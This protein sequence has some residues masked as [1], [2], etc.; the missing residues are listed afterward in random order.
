MKQKKTKLFLTFLFMLFCMQT[1]SA[2]DYER[3]VAIYHSKRYEKAKEMFLKIIKTQ[4][5]GNSLYYLGEI[6]KIEGKYKEAK[7]YFTRAVKAKSIGVSNLKS[8][9]WNIAAIEEQWGEYENLV[10]ICHEIW[11]KMKD[12][13]A[14]RKIDAIINKLQWSNNANAV[15][16]YHKGIEMKKL[17]K[18]DEAVLNFREALKYD[19]LFIAPKFELGILAVQDDDMDAAEANLNPVISKI[20]FYAEAN[21]A[22]GDVYFNKRNFSLARICYERAVRFG[23]LNSQTSYHINIQSAQCYYNEGSFVKAEEL[24]SQ[25]ASIAPEQTEPLTLISAIYIKQKDFE[26]ALNILQKAQS[27]QPD[28]N[29]VLYQLGS[30]YYNRKDERYLANFDKLFNLTKEKPKQPY[31]LIVPIIIRAHYAQ[32]NYSRVSEIFASL[33]EEQNNEMILIKARSFYYTGQYDKA[34]TQLLKTD[35]TNED[36]FLLAS[37]YAREHQNE[38]ATETLKPL[39]NDRELKTKI[40]QDQFLAPLAMEIERKRL[41]QQRLAEQEKLEQERRAKQREIERQAEKDRIER[42]KPEKGNQSPV[43]ENRQKDGGKS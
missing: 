10:L 17:S 1:A 4:E 30:I 39:M 16:E 42:N 23:F 22:L 40:L 15:A 9:Y 2:N 5:N 38:Q 19:P 26:K 7:E 35:I 37:A 6:E 27:I 43:Q 12:E 33:P 32:K 25:A 31:P 28:N 11:N 34:I 36:K 8:A 41:E 14:R 3:A 21:I 24:A 18:T 13:S 29:D 20:P